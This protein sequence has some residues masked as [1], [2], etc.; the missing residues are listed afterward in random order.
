[1]KIGEV[2]FLT[3]VHSRRQLP[4]PVCPEV[5]FAGRSNVG[6]SSLINTLLGRRKL[7]KTSSRPGK[8]RGLNFFSVDDQL[9][10]VD[11]PGYGF[12]RVSRRE[13]AGWQTLISSYLRERT[14]LVLVVVILDLRHPLKT[15]DRQLIDWLNLEGI[16]HVPVYTKADKLSRNKQMSHAAALDAA[17]GLDPDQRVIFSALT[18]QGREKLLDKLALARNSW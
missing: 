10:L 5:A 17:L 15:M 7:V 16:A 2:R 6:K 11:L 4:D 13:Q 18:G 8:T 3:S 1:M 9:Y 14:S 12:A